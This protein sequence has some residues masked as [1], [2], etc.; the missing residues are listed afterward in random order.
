MPGQD[1]Y[2]ISISILTMNHSAPPTILLILF[3]F[4]FVGMWCF[5]SKMISSTSGWSRLAE[6][7]P[8]RNPPS[9][10]RFFMQGGRV[11]SA[12]YS[13]VLNIYTSQE[14]LYLSVMFL[15]RVGTPPLFIPWSAIR[16]VK[17]HRFLWAETVEF[18]VG[19]PEAVT[20]QLPKKVFEGTPVFLN[21]AT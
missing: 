20:F 21:T 18:D 1:G 13:G 19:S 2:T 14:G 8:A 4:F 5:V 3:P 12:R 11:G 9:G 16:Y 10:K 7:F 15:F 6:T 17:T